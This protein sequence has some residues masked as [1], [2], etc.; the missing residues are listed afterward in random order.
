M[1]IDNDHSNNLLAFQINNLSED[2]L[3]EI[4]LSQSA[5]DLS[6]NLI[7]V[8]KKWKN[9]INSNSFWILKCLK[10]K[11]LNKTLINILNERKIEIDGRKIYF[12][13][14]FTRNF[15][16][17]SCGE[18]NFDYWQF[19]EFNLN[20]SNYPEN[21]L[22]PKNVQNIIDSYKLNRFLKK[23]EN[24]W[25]FEWANTYKDWAIEDKQTG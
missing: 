15:L 22:S 2:L 21:K 16:K 6:K 18:K 5:K 8:C 10:D 4:F 9:I 19:K 23:K 14:F 13:N 24:N 17:N 3:E 20:I 25:S 12:E 7:I 11:K 1:N